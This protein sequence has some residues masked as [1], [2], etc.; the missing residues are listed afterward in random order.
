MKYADKLRVPWIQC[1]DLAT[2]RGKSGRQRRISEIA[3]MKIESESD[4]G[5]A[6]HVGAEQSIA[7]KSVSRGP[8]R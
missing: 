6:G 8:C 2:R 5:W 3:E 7:G 1:H 4:L